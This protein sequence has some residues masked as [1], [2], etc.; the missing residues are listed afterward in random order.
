METRKL[1]QNDS[2]FDN[3]ALKGITFIRT[4]K[5]HLKPQQLS[6]QSKLERLAEGVNYFALSVPKKITTALGT[7]GPV[8]VSARITN[9]EAFIVSLFPTGGGRH[10]LRVKAKDRNEVEIQE[11]DRLQ[12]QI[13]VL[14]Q[15][16]TP[17]PKD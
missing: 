17:I 11:G 5:R 3:L 10:Y 4:M 14:D 7:I 1:D 13:T 9:S 8:P 12:V 6:F 2:R 16:K 15:S